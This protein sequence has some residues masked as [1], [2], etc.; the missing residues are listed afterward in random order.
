[1]RLHA[2]STIRHQ[3]LH[4]ALEELVQ[5]WTNE[6][7]GLVSDASVLDL[8]DWSQQQ[9]YTATCSLCPMVVDEDLPF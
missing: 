5:C 8:L 7:G 9:T 6:T 1:M 2:P 3:T 4:Q